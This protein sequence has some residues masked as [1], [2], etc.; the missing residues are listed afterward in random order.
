VAPVGCEADEDLAVQV[1]AVR[2]VE[3]VLEGSVKS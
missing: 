1:Q 3:I 2:Q